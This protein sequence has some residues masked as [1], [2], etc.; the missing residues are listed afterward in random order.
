MLNYKIKSAIKKKFFL[1][2]NIINYFYFL[3]F[4]TLKTNSK[5]K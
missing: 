4:E 1:K 2:I 3:F 5:I